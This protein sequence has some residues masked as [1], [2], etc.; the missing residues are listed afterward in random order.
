[1]RIA[2]RRDEAPILIEILARE[3]SGNGL[4]FLV[5]GPHLYLAESVPA[6]FIVFPKIRRDSA[7]KLAERAPKRKEKP[8][9]AVAPGSFTVQPHHLPGSQLAAKGSKK[10]AKAGWKKDSRKERHKRDL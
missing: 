1:L 7:E 9:P 4:S 3:A 2:K 10:D 6:A 5:A 8:S